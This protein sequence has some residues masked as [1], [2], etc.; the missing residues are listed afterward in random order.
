M[1]YRNASVLVAI[2]LLG[3]A[4]SNLVELPIPIVS[5][6]AL[7][8]PTVLYLSPSWVVGGVLVALVASGSYSLARSRPEVRSRGHLY[9]LTFAG[10]PSAVTVVALFSLRLLAPWTSFGA[11]LLLTGLLLAAIFVAHYHLFQEG[12][13]LP[14]YWG[15]NLAVYGVA[16]FLYVVIYAMKVRSLLSASG[17]SL[18]SAA[19]A[20]ETLRGE[21]PKRSWLYALI[22]GLIMGQITWTLNYWGVG[23]LAGGSV[24]L[25]TFY[26]VV[27][28]ARQHLQGR[29]GKGN[30]AEFVLLAGL[31]AVILYAAFLWSW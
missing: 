15:L 31:G 13:S 25:L 20:V 10:L 11:G 19:L 2:V 12:S 6:A 16:A 5:F 1:Y 3:L 18:L 23:A 17:I 27:G 7:G 28:L 22:C 9:A 21:E 14:A 24:L 29:L 30:V 8:S 26:L 4:I